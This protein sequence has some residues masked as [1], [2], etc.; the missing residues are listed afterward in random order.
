MQFQLALLGLT[1]TAV[2]VLAVPA[3]VP[4]DSAEV[5]RMLI[6][7]FIWCQKLTSCT[8]FDS[9]PG[10]K[11]MAAAVAADADAVLADG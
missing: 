2:Q 7:L 6:A 10:D 3:E 9:F 1:A 11:T 8:E 5:T 4:R